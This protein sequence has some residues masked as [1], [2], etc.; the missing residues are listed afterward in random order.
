MPH[1]CHLSSWRLR[2]YSYHFNVSHY[3][4]HCS[5]HF[6]WKMD[7]TSDTM[8]IVCSIFPS[9]SHFSQFPT[10]TQCSR[11]AIFVATLWYSC[12]VVFI[13]LHV[14]FVLRCGNG[15]NISQVFRYSCLPFLTVDK[16]LHLTLVLWANPRTVIYW[17]IINL[18]LCSLLSCVA[19]LIGN[20]GYVCTLAVWVAVAECFYQ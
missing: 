2:W 7:P 18:H 8:S 15:C 20:V 6:W 12:S 9:L 1:V 5:W 16:F 3:S 13:W 4:R 10:I 11:S 14:R 17:T 19:I